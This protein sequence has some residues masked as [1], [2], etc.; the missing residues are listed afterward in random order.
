MTAY[1]L[2]S[3]LPAGINENNSAFGIPNSEGKEMR[4][5]YR[6]PKT[7]AVYCDQCSHHVIV[8]ARVDEDFS[9]AR[10]EKCANCLGT[11]GRC[12]KCDEENRARR[13][14]KEAA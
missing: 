1:K 10:V 4:S 3:M 8:P 7:V 2:D 11:G 13:S 6:K 9:R 12:K 5:K 14:K